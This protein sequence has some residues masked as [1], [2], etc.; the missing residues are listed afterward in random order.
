[1]RP[2][3]W[4]EVPA[5][6]RDWIKQSQALRRTNEATIA[7]SLADLHARF[8]QI[9]PLLDGPGCRQPARL[10]RLPALA[11]EQSSANASRVAAIRGRLKGRQ[12]SRRHVQSPKAWVDEYRATRTKRA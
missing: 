4:T 3:A 7:E 8:E 5:L 6:T 11:S 12:G 9:H 2:P 10:V 1:M